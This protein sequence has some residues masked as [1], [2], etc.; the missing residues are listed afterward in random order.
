LNHK[1]ALSKVDLTQL[2]NI[3]ARLK[4]FGLRISVFNDSVE[5]WFARKIA[6]FYCEY[7][8]FYKIIQKFDNTVI[9]NLILHV[10]TNVPLLGKDKSELSE[11]GIAV[12]GEVP[13]DL[14]ER[15][16]EWT[17]SLFVKKFTSITDRVNHSL[18]LNFILV[19][20]YFKEVNQLDLNKRKRLKNL[21]QMSDDLFLDDQEKMLS[22][23]NYLVSVGLIEKTKDVYTFNQDIYNTWIQQPV[24]ITLNEFY[25]E[26][27]NEQVFKLLK[28][29]SI[30]QLDHEEWVDMTI[31]SDT[32]IEYDHSRQLGLINVYK[33]G[34][35]SYVQLTPEGWL[36][37]KGEFHPSWNE[38]LILVTASDEVFVPY[39]F[40]PFMIL[41]IYEVGFLKDLGYFLVFE[42]NLDEEWVSSKIGRYFYQT[43]IGNSIA[44]PSV[45][46][47][48]FEKHF[49]AN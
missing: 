42:I 49:K 16:K 20:G 15:I 36:I 23:I 13:S 45:V 43:L 48:E 19:L 17:R 9:Q 2:E 12:N 32:S 11:V 44:I 14:K 5:T 41:N 34:N 3:Y 21:T 27:S 38:R 47:Y 26:V 24:D 6:E 7:A 37:V 35:K 22:L 25:K 31:L 8:N 18:F 10:Y 29:I 46:K 4:V 40:D 30:Y 33:D 1:E 39:Y 28:K